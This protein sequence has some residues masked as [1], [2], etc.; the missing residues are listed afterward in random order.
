MSTETK[1]QIQ[2]LIAKWTPLHAH[3]IKLTLAYTSG[4]FLR[5]SHKRP[6]IGTTRQFI[7]GLLIGAGLAPSY[8]S[9]IGPCGGQVPSIE[10]NGPAN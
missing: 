8:F 7:E 9:D 5:I 2:A 1:R 3:G 6:I 4:G 10:W